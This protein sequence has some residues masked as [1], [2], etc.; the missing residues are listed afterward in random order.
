M[1]TEDT[2]DSVPDYA[3]HIK[4]IARVLADLKRPLTTPQEG[5]GDRRIKV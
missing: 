2:P 4:I 1:L 5:L 3:D